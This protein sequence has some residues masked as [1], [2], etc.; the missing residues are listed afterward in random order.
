MQCSEHYLKWQNLFHYCK[1]HHF[2]PIFVTNVFHLLD[3]VWGRGKV[4]LFLFEMTEED[5]GESSQIFLTHLSL[6]LDRKIVR[7]VM[8]SK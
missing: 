1:I 2:G 6:S 7:I 4:I 5:C 8:K 3:L